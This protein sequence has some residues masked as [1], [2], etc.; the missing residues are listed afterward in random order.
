MDR[1]WNRTEEEK[2]N[3][4]PLSELTPESLKDIDMVVEVAH[5]SIVQKYA[6]LILEH[7]DLFVS[8]LFRSFHSPSFND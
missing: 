2:E 5:P 1:I 6:G 8:D 7:S 4:L 3:V